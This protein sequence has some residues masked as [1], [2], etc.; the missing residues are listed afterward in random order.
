M[1]SHSTKEEKKEDFPAFLSFNRGISTHALLDLFFP[2]MF[3]LLTH[4][5]YE[6]DSSG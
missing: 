6:D 3:V 5:S 4:Y 2:D 1:K